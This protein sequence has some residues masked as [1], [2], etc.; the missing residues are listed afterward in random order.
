[1]LGPLGNT[2]ASFDGSSGGLVAP[3]PAL[4]A[5]ATLEGWFRWRAGTSML[6][7]DT[8]SGGWLLAF[9]SAGELFYRLGGRGFATGRPIGAVRDGAWHHLVATKS[10]TNTAL[11]LDGVRIHSGTGAGSAPAVSPWHVMRNGTNAVFSEGEADEVALYGRALSA[12]EI[13]A[14]HDLALG[15]AAGRLPPESP[16]AAVEPPAAGTGLGGGVLGSAAGLPRSAT[17]TASVRGRRLVVRGPPG[18]A[19]RLLARRRGGAW[20]VSDGRA[21]LRAGAGCRPITSRAV[22]CPAA[23][24]KRIALFGGAGNDRLTVVGRARAL[25]DGGRG[26]DRLKAV[27]RTRALLDGGRGNDRL[28]VIGR[29]AVTFRG[30]P[31][32]DAIT[33]RRP[34]RAGGR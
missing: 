14:H 9:D 29:A 20:Q 16:A 31:G 22:S 13:R 24:I 26:D 6:R 23:P 32:V 15:L 25:L 8:G 21:G 33:R 4:S 18:R 10:G 34:P 3:G 30:G 1:V 11:Y 2:A 19:S 12:D 17:G 28:I 27:G 5:D 7:D